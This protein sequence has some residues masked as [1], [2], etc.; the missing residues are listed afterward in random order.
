MTPTTVGDLPPND[1]VAIELR[2]R[3]YKVAHKT[4]RGREQRKVEGVDPA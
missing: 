3:G 4:V 2:L 1:D